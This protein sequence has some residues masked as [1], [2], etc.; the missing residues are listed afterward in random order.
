MP[1][2]SPAPKRPV[3]LKGHQRR[4]QLL[5]A[6]IDLVDVEGMAAFTMERVAARAEVSKP[7]L[8]S[9]FE[10][11]AALLIALLERHWA[12][13]DRRVRL[14]LQTTSTFDEHVAAIIAGYFDASVEAGRVFHQL[15]VNESH[16][17]V[18]EEARARRHRESEALWS[19]VY[20]SKFALSPAVA[21]VVASILR[22]SLESAASYWLRAP[23]AS[24]ELCAGVCLATF[25]GTL[26][27]VA[28]GHNVW[29]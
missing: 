23:D 20:Q 11:R 14:R 22:G 7:V 16:D 3:R 5:D 12:D 24:R 13:L 8:Y 25:R 18:V 21:S 27:E 15:L 2:S 10:N 1:T 28:K 9:H 4:E 26:D 19:A 17:P 6:A 29:W